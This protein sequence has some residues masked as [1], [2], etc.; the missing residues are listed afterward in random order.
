MGLGTK[1]IGEPYTLEDKDLLETLVNNL[2]VSLKNARAAQALKEAYDEVT[3]LNQAKDK[4][5]HHMAHELQT[6]LALLKS[7]LRMLGRQLESVPSEKWER[8]MQRA[9]RSIQRLV[10][11]QIEVNDIIQK[12]ES[13]ERNMVSCLLDQ[14]TD[15]LED[16]IVEQTADAVIVEKIR[17]RIDE[18]FR[19]RPLIPETLFLAQ[20]VQTQMQKTRPL[21]DHRNVEVILETEE[22]P[23]I[24]I[25]PDPLEKLIVGLFK[26]A[27]EYTPDEGRIEVSVK[28]GGQGAVFTVRDAGVGIESSHLK[29]IFK[30]FFPT[31]DTNAYSSGK[32]YDF[33]AGGKGAD[34]LRLKLFSERYN[35]QLDLQTT[36]CSFIPHQSDV[37]PGQISEC[38]FCRSLEDCYRSGGTTV[39]ALFTAAENESLSKNYRED[40][41]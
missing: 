15:V 31:R 18:I 32:P 23:P 28:P 26:N 14:C 37:C 33:N 12:S 1:I 36:R 40:K 8:T 17:G 7:A 20:F 39:R 13:R 6:P 16:L 10:D 27:V 2:M 5:I 4:M 3:T 30:G 29:L 41:T 34:L 22:T 25:P 21:Y 38:S 11:M 19:P 24:W 9:E 35:F